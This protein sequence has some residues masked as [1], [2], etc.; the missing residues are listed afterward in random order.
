LRLL[1]CLGL[2]SARPSAA[3]VALLLRGAFLF[4]SDRAC[5]AGWGDDVD[6]AVDGWGGAGS[7]VALRKTDG[8]GIVMAS[9]AIGGP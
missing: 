1:D 2:A 7:G 9:A 8:D 5:W 4:P 6:V 3:L